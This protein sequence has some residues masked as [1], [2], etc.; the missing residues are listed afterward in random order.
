MKCNLYFLFLLT[1]CYFTFFLQKICWCTLTFSVCRTKPVFLLYATWKH[2]SC[3]S[4]NHTA[5]GSPVGSGR[6]H[7]WT[8]WLRLLLSSTAFWL[9]QTSA[10]SWEHRNNRPTA[11]VYPSK[12]ALCSAVCRGTILTWWKHEDSPIQELMFIFPAQHCHRVEAF[13]ILCDWWDEQLL[14]GVA[15]IVFIINVTVQ[16]H[17]IHEND[18]PPSENCVGTK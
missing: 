3:G 4:D 9:H 17:R 14:N 13:V 6:P 8:R 5:D 12:H 15:K 16:F 10:S 2:D 7:R 11:N 18:K 1:I